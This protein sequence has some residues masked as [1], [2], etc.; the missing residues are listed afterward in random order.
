M[1]GSQLRPKEARHKLE[2]FDGDTE[3][4]SSWPAV[5]AL[6]CSLPAAGAAL[7]GMKWERV[8]IT[9]LGCFILL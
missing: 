8:T 5:P 4:T 6:R 7:Y 1:E 9:H 2:M 3:G